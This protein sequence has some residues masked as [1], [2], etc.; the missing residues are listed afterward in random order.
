MGMNQFFAEQLNVLTDYTTETCFISDLTADFLPVID[1]KYFATII[2]SFLLKI[3]AYTFIQCTYI[4]CMSVLVI[5]TCTVRISP[6]TAIFICCIS[7]F[8]LII[9][10][11]VLQDFG[12]LIKKHV[13]V[14]STPIAGEP[15][16]I[17][18]GEPIYSQQSFISFESL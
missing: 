18:K 12:E 5:T 14:P 17:A 13:L 11:C 16:P 15:I 4:H 1:L 10:V 7:M 8:T 9:H 6:T 3:T 2:Q